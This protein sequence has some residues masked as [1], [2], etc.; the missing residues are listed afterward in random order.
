MPFAM[1]ADLTHCGALLDAM[2]DPALLVGQDRRILLANPAAR[3]LFS[4]PLTGASAL[5]Y[6]R[7]PEPAA[8]LDRAMAA[9]RV[10]HAAVDA[11]IFVDAGTGAFS[12][13]LCTNARFSCIKPS[14]SP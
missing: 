3:E 5:S 1:T 6:L 11:D 2:P 7:Q 9:G 14:S 13:I 10:R 12:M 4:A 8:A